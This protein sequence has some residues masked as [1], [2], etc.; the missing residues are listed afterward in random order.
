MQ[1][2]EKFEE[3]RILCEEGMFDT[4]YGEYIMTHSNGE[5]V[6]GNGNTL[7]FHIERGYLFDDFVGYLTIKMLTKIANT[8]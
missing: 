4:E 3:I 1:F 5:Y 2:K 7:L 6:I 8:V